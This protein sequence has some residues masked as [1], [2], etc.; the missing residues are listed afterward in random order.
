MKFI[1]KEY[2]LKELAKET[3]RNYSW[4]STKAQVIASHCGCRRVGGAIVFP[5][6]AIKFVNETWEHRNKTSEET[7]IKSN[8]A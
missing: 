2:T 1:I 4:L 6:S 7:E 8:N 5:E 3:N